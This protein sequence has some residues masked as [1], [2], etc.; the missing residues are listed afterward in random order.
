M[1]K[2]KKG[3][4][5]GAEVPLL[6]TGVVIALLGVLLGAGL[7]LWQESAYD[8][9]E[10]E[11][12]TTVGS[13]AQPRSSAT[14]EKAVKDQKQLL[15]SNTNQAT[16]TTQVLD[17]QSSVEAA[18]NQRNFKG[19]TDMMADKVYFVEEATECCGMI[20]KAA[21]ARQFLDYSAGTKLFNFA[22][23][24]QAV[25]Q[26]RVNLVDSFGPKKFTKIGIGNDNK[27]VAYHL[28]AQNKVD[29]LYI[30]VNLDLFDLE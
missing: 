21:A 14:D 6:M 16:K 8:I 23:T 29:S 7:Y 17:A 26:M 20:G 4:F 28:N 9:G 2:T 27:V 30:A 13:G 24:Q 1:A 5:G 15:N 19:L 12:L 10:S 3:K 18:I 22:E 11:V 25:K